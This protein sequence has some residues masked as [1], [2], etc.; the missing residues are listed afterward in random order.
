MTPTY[1]KKETKQVGIWLDH[2]TANVMDIKD[3]IISSKTIESET[4]T[5]HQEGNQNIHQKSMDHNKHYHLMQYIKTLTEIIINYDEVLLFGPSNAK[6]ELH[7]VLKDN[8]RF[9]KIKVDVKPE[10]RLTE[11]QQYAFVRE[12]FNLPGR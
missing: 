7:N 11:K 10:D 3:N 6:L 2:S 12:H 9:D 4:Y 1:S 8:H 5:Q